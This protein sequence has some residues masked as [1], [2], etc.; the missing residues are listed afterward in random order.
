MKRCFAHLALFAIL[1]ANTYALNVNP[2]YVDSRQDGGTFSQ[3]SVEV[4][5]YSDTR[6]IFYCPTNVATA[7]LSFKMSQYTSSTG[8]TTYVFVTGSDIARSSNVASFILMATNVPYSG[9]YDG[10]LW[11][12]MMDGYKTPVARGIVTVTRSLFDTATDTYAFPVVTNDFYDIMFDAISNKTGNM[13]QNGNTNWY[14]SSGSATGTVRIAGLI[15]LNGNVF[16]NFEEMVNIETNTGNEFALTIESNRLLFTVNT[17]I[18]AAGDYSTSLGTNLCTGTAVLTAEITRIDFPMTF[19]NTPAVVLGMRGDRAT[20]VTPNIVDIDT[21]GFTLTVLTAGSPL[22]SGLCDWLACPNG[23]VEGAKVSLYI[24]N[25]IAYADNLV[26]TNTAFARTLNASESI[27]LNDQAITA[28]PESIVWSIT[29]DLFDRW[30]AAWSNMFSW[31]GSNILSAAAG[32]ASLGLGTVATKYLGAGLGSS[33]TNLIVSPA[34]GTA[35]GGIKVG[36]NLN[37]EAD[38]TLSVELPYLATDYDPYGGLLNAT[39]LTYTSTANGLL[40][41]SGWANS[42]CSAAYMIVYRNGNTHFLKHFLMKNTDDPTRY[43]E[44]N[45]PISVSIGTVITYVGY[46]DTT[47]TNTVAISIRHETIGGIQ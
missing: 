44:W 42:P 12:V 34:T 35:I 40:F 45:I 39:F 23:L 43:A 16:S 10:E 27:V 25:G 14:L 13:I 17:N 26:I 3:F 11:G 8:R 2:V 37:V 4:D 29:S 19:S 21:N 41:S 9:V 46:G 7:S 15:D 31:S 1:C 20:M 32:R 18:Q 33:G 28:W 24:S 38:G 30:S 47:G 22:T 36:D 6:F 5:G